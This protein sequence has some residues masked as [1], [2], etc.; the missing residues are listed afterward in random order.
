[1]SKKIAIIGASEFQCPLILKAKEMGLE[2][3]VFAW[4]CGDVGES[5]ADF[6]YPISITEIDE[7]ISICRDVGVDGVCTIGTDLGNIT[8]SNV[9][10]TLGL[11]ANSVE[12]VQRST[13]KH[14][15]REAFNRGGDPSP[16]SLQVRSIEDADLSGLKFPLIVKPV[17]RSG[18]R[19][20]TKVYEERDLGSA[21]EEAVGVSFEKAAV[22]EEFL[23]GTE[24]SVE[25]VSWRGHHTFLALT[26]KFTTGAPHFIETGHLEPALVDSST[27]EKVKAVVSHAL[28]SLGVMFGA[29]HSEIKI[30]PEGRIGIVEIGT[31]MGGDCIGSHLVPLST[32]IDFMKA[33]I[34]ISLGEEPDLYPIS[35]G[36]YS[37]I[38]FI[39]GQE[40]LDVLKQIEREA[41]DALQL[42]AVDESLSGEIVD[43]S[44]RHGF[45]ILK[46]TDYSQLVPFF[47]K[48]DW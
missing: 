39:F 42:S 9:A 11:T 47:P 5:A 44:S 35:E 29:S 22:V 25:F 3:H 32:G 7:I 2:T 33:V 12:C 34:Q 43:S 8:V 31:R 21:I 24:Y 13:N 6:F 17:D 1:M 27:L 30:S 36:Q 46:A 19:C 4:K 15:M 40:D 28:D 18:S 45:Y 10:R 38:R 16:K 41:S 26:R 48:E 20:V 23:E 37:M 14:L